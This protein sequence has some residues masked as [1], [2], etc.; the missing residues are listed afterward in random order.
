MQ[1]EYI[2]TTVEAEKLGFNKVFTARLLKVK[3]HIM[4]VNKKEK[5]EELIQN[6]KAFSC[7]GLHLYTGTMIANSKDI[8][9]AQK[10]VIQSRHQHKQKK[11]LTKQMK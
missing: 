3:N 5:V 6:N 1:D 11:V 8:L 2:R 9:D 4:K 10:R 7:S